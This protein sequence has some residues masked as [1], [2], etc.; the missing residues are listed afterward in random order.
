MSR[1][2]LVIRARRP[3]SKNQQASARKEENRAGFL[4]SNYSW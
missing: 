4:V 3:A 1:V 2:L